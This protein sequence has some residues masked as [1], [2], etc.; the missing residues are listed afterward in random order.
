MNRITRRVAIIVL[1]GVLFSL[2]TATALA[3]DVHADACVGGGCPSYQGSDP[4]SAYQYDYVICM[5]EP[6]VYEGFWEYVGC[7]VYTEL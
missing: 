2:G 4:W 6:G 5:V 3:C 1:S 7:C